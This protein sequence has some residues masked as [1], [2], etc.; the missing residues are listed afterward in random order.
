MSAEDD[1]HAV[2]KWTEESFSKACRIP[3][4]Y[5]NQLLDLGLWFSP[6]IPCFNGGVWIAKPKTTPGNKFDGFEPG[7]LV[8]LG[9]SDLP[10]LATARV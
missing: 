2:F 9:E 7:G 4:A 6:P 5:L 1:Y 8:L 3:R 10:W